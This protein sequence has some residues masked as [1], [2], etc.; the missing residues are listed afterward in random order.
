MSQ[1]GRF[2]YLDG[3]PFQALELPYKGDSLAM[4]IFLPREAD[5]L[6]GF[7]ATLTVEKLEASLA[8]LSPRRVEVG[9]P[10]FEL[11]G[12]FSLETTLGELGMPSA[13]RPDR[14]DFSGMT[15]QRGIAISAV[16]HKAFV[17]VEERGTEAAAATGVVIVRAEAI[18]P[19]P[20]VFRADHPFLFLICDVRTGSILFLGRLVRPEA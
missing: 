17:E 8:K 13:F 15:D 7:E 14:A 16:V 5:G 3:G 9:F 4:V 12:Q 18:V 19:P 20:V 1:T 10:K 6:A 11:S 2:R